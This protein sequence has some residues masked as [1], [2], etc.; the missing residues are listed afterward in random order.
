MRKVFVVAEVYR[1]FPREPRLRLAQR[2]FEHVVARPKHD[3]LN[4]AAQEIVE[5]RQQQIDPLV[6]HESR[7]HP[8]NRRVA[9]G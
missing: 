4:V 3:Q 7:H 2:R 5:T 6:P 1:H 9:D 8:K